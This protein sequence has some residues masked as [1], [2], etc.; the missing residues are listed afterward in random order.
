MTNIECDNTQEY[1]VRA[2]SD[3]TVID[4]LPP[5]SIFKV[6]RLLHL[7]ETTNPVIFGS[8]LDSRLLGKK[9]LLKI[10]DQYFDEGELGY[11]TLVAPSAT[12]SV[13]RDFNVVE[14][15]Q[16]TP[17]EVVEGF[18]R[19]ANP[20]CITNHERITTHFNVIQQSGELSLRCKYCE[21]ITQQEQ[22][23]IVK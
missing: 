13:I 5:S 10:V 12:I 1:Q 21:K 19:C 15:R 23:E 17:P 3:G 22:I 16:I 4:H 6:I 14:K 2:I 20:M 11:L 18:V 7:E 8:N 9:A